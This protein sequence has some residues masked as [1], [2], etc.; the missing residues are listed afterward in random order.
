MS[1]RAVSVFASTSAAL[2]ALALGGCV[3][4]F[5]QSKPVQLYELSP[6]FEPSA[7]ATKP[8]QIVNVRLA[9]ISF[10][11]ASAGDRMLTVRDGEAAYI[12]GARWVSP[13]STLFDQDLQRAFAE[14]GGAVRLL[15]RTT[16]VSAQFALSVDVERFQVRYGADGTPTVEIVLHAQTI[17]FPD[18]T[19]V[20]DSRITMARK[21][22]ANRVTAIVKAYGDALAAALTTVVERTDEAAASA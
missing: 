19:I 16:T 10:E 3:S 9:G 20:S 5:P 18:R 22:D 4:L 14:H 17:R 1:R 11:Q 21:A 7:A 15:P 8:R 12:G 2:A 13:A 6:S